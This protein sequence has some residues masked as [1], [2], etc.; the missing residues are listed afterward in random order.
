MEI[1][2]YNISMTQRDA[3]FIYLFIPSSQL[4]VSVYLE[5]NNF[6]R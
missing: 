4:H 2:D 1:V 5:N 3:V 6:F